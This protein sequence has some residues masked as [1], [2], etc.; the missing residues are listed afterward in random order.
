M[1]IAPN[2]YDLSAAEQNAPDDTKVEYVDDE[3]TKKKF[4]YS[5]KIGAISSYFNVSR[6][7]AKYIYHRRRKGFPYKK[8]DD[9]N[10]IKWDMRIQNALIKA[11]TL[12]VWNWKELSFYDDVYDLQNHGIDVLKQSYDVYKNPKSHKVSHR[13][14]S[15]IDEETNG[16]WTIVTPSKKKMHDKFILKKMGFLRPK[17]LYKMR[18]LPKDV[19]DK[20]KVE[21]A[22]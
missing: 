19:V 7:A 17:K 5:E 9:P 11:D 4:I 15:L 18:R 21:Q 8:V 12:D 22:E 20:L 10:F 3:T 6:E 16:E 1:E 14:E 13:E 2:R